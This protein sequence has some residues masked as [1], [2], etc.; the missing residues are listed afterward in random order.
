MLNLI[1][2]REDFSSEDF[3]YIIMIQNNYEEYLYKL[4]D[5]ASGEKV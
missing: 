1:L 5:V 4:N 2:K 3:I